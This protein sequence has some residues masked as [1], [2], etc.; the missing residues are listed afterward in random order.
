MCVFLGWCYVYVS[1]VCVMCMFLG[2]CYVY[3]SRFV[4]CACFYVGVMYVFLDSRQVFVLIGECHAC[5]S[6]MV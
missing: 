5:V 3:V 6:K 2:W 4:L 1:L